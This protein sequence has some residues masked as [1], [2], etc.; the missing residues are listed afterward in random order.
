MKNKLKVI[1]FLLAVLFICPVCLTACGN[2]DGGGSKGGTNQQTKS[3]IAQVVD[4]T[5]EK[6][7]TAISKLIKIANVT[8]STNTLG[9]TSVKY[10]EMTIGDYLSLQSEAMQ[11]IYMLDY[12]TMNQSGGNGYADIEYNKAYTGMSLYDDLGYVLLL[13]DEEGIMHVKADLL[14]QED[15]YGVADCYVMYNGNNEAREFGFASYSEVSLAQVVINFDSN[16]FEYFTVDA[17]SI[18]QDPFITIDKYNSG[19]LT[20]ADFADKFNWSMCIGNITDDYNNLDFKGVKSSVSGSNDMSLVDNILFKSTYKTN[21]SK[22][23]LRK[24]AIDST[25]ATFLTIIEDGEAYAGNKSDINIFVD[26]ETG[27]TYYGST[28]I[29]LPNAINILANVSTEMGKNAKF[30]NDIKG[31][32][33]TLL[34]YVK[35]KGSRYVGITASNIQYDGM[36]VSVKVDLQIATSGN[37]LQGIITI[38]PMKESA[39]TYRMEVDESKYVSIVYDYDN[40]KVVKVSDSNG[41]SINIG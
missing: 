14:Y 18:Q 4:S 12:L 30:T 16:R 20:F 33:S 19:A 15:L 24:V 10:D 3:K 9:A 39:T 8:A 26:S 5:V 32:V 37:K 31:L 2:D 28:Y 41:N 35:I 38:N 36:Q 21:Y 34:G 13:T 27:R 22:C 40:L 17:G 6:L 29:D 7:D 1:A 11:I 25:N 23:Q